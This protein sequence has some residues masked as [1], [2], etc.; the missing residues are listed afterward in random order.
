[1]SLRVEMNDP[2]L[3]WDVTMKTTPVLRAMNAVNARLPLFTWRFSALVNVRAWMARR[4]FGMGKVSLSATMPS[5]HFGILMP[6]RV[7]FIEKSRARFEGVDLGEPERVPLNPTIGNV[8]LSAR[9]AFAVGRGFW[10]IRDLAEYEHV[11][12]ELQS[13][14]GDGG[15]VGP[16]P[17][18]VSR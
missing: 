12:E 4:V 13:I 7:F 2:A 15:N 18:H 16:D 9:P 8:R 1:M 3:T 5:G 10:K 11:R 6:L 17:V 14:V